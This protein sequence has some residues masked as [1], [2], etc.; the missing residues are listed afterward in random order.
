MIRRATRRI[1]GAAE[2]GMMYMLDMLEEEIGIER[3]ERVYDAALRH[4]RAL[5]ALA[6]PAGLMI[7]AGIGLLMI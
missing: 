3:M 5:Y 1:R 4:R 2:M 7:G 6:V